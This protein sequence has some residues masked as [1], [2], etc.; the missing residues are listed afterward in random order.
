LGHNAG[1]T[2]AR[3]QARS[4][5]ESKEQGGA[6]SGYRVL[7]LTDSRGAY[8]SKLLADLGA[9]VIKIEGPEGDP[10]AGGASLCERCA[11]P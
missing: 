5:M 11:S 7:D 3:W 1:W 6:L 9:D 10:G 4:A 2:S 8:C